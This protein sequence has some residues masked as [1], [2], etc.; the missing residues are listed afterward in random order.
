MAALLHTLIIWSAGLAAA[1]SYAKVSVWFT[2]LGEVYPNTGAWLA[3]AVSAVSLL[4]AICGVLAG[5]LVAGWGYRKTLIVSLLITAIT[6]MGEAAFPAF[7]VFLAL[8]IVEGGAHLAIVVAA[9]TLMAQIVPDRWRSA[10]LSLWSTFFA[11]TFALTALVGS[12]MTLPQ[13]F[14]LHGAFSIAVALAMCLVPKAMPEPLPPSQSILQHHAALYASPFIS[15]PAIGWLF[16]TTCFVALITVWPATLPSDLATLAAG[17]MP[18]VGLAA[19]M[20]IGATMLMRIPA[21]VVVLSGFIVAALAATLLAVV[22]GSLALLFAL[23][24]GFGVIQSSSFALVPQLV[25]TAQERASA[26]GAMAQMGNL[27]NMIG[28]PLLASLG[29]APSIALT[30]AMLL[31][32]GTACHWVLARRRNAA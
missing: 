9:P 8:R 7:S 26:N 17:A 29:S 28:T 30:V 4:G 18:L 23:C 24:I 13:L 22:P 5:R 20:T 25:E 2:A 3:A 31:G 19:A 21:Y 32:V 16:Y 14:L 1:G 11:V 27:G 6:S 12:L 10:A 15:A